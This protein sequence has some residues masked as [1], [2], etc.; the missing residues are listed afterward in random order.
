MRDA[1]QLWLSFSL[2]ICSCCTKVVP[3]TF[4]LKKKKS[5]KGRGNS[6]HPG[7]LSPARLGLNSEAVTEED[8]G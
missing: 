6:S 3:N 5:N 8:A 7:V 2:E 1:F 4:F